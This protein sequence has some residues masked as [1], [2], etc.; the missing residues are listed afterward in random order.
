MLL[1]YLMDN[2]KEFQ[3][4]HSIQ[5]AT[6]IEKTDDMIQYEFQSMHSD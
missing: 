4:T 2:I 3:S 5:S 1:K 6:S